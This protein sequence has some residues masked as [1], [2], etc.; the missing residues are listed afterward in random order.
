MSMIAMQMMVPVSI[1]FWSVSILLSFCDLHDPY[2]DIVSV[3][4][5]FAL[6]EFSAI[7]LASGL[8]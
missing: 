7:I 3:P 6:L 1:M 4:I 2:A 5:L 8:Y